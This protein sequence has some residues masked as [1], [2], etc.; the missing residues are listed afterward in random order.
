MCIRDSIYTTALPPHSIAVIQQAYNALHHCPEREQ[1]LE[2][3]RFFKTHFQHPQLI[4][5]KSPIQCIVVGGNKK[6]KAVATALQSKGMDVRPILHP[7]V[8]EGTERI[9]ICLHSY[10]TTEEIS[11]L[12]NQLKALV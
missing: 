10:N 12:C 5:S 9:R 7:T 11:L 2:N 3:I 4:E 1:L 8:S 6:T